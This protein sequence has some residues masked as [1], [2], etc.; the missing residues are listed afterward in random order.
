MSDEQDIRRMGGIWK[1]VKVTWALMWVGSLALAGIPFF[2]GYYS[3]DMILEA[4]WAAGTPV[5]QAA[6]WLGILAAVLTAFYSWRLLLLTFH[7][8]P[9]ADEQVMAHVHESPAVMIVPLLFLGAGAMFAGWIGYDM[10]VGSASHDFWGHALVVLDTH[11]ALVNAHHVPG[12]VALMP[13]IAA[14]G[15]IAVAYVL[16]V[17]APSLPAMLAAAMPGLH[18][19]LLNKWYFDEFYDAVLVRPAFRLG[20]GLWKGGD[21]ALIDGLGPD[22]VAANSM[23]LGRRVA[24]AE[25]GY[26][27]HYAFAM[28]IG[29]AGFVTWY[30]LFTR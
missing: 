22:G 30:I 5:G 10:F 9:R 29:V 27:F 25:T 3:K 7:G 14:A 6:Y 23:R 1:H 26:L 19:F 12:W 20:R 24:A 16:Y 15:G 2:A 13:T 11:P 18:R 28:L 21:G 17:F 8:R 4:A